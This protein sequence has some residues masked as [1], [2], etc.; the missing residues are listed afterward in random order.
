LSARYRVAR[1]AGRF[2]VVA[3]TA[4]VRELGAFV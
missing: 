1:R 3:T 2:D 4:V